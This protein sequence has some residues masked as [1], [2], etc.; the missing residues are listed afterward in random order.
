[1]DLERV[2]DSMD[3]VEVVV[4][5]MAVERVKDSMGSVEVVVKLMHLVEV[6][7]SVG[8]DSKSI[9]ESIIYHNKESFAALEKSESA[10]VLIV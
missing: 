3:S 6:E 8:V 2:E 10:N 4:G 1:M 7:G 5:S 9:L